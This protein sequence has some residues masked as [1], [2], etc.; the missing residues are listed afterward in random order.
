MLGTVTVGSTATKEKI[1]GAFAAIGS[2]IA[3]NF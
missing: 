1:N 2:F 3:E